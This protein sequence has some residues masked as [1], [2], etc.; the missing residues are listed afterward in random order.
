ML[1]LIRGRLAALAADKHTPCT[2]QHNATVLLQRKRRLKYG[3]VRRLS[4]IPV[5][6]YAAAFSVAFSHLRYD[7]GAYFTHKHA[8]VPA[9]EVVEQE[10]FSVLLPD[11]RYYVL[12]HNVG[13]KVLV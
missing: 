10:Q 1:V 6:L 7:F 3:A 5:F 9:V 8:F 12:V 2:T 11:S 13:N 4:T